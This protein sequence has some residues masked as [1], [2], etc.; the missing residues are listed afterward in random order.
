MGTEVLV[1]PIAGTA[2]RERE[3]DELTEGDGGSSVGRGKKK[4]SG[5]RWILDRS[6]GLRTLRYILK[7]RSARFAC[8]TYLR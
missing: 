7:D 6:D 5:F 4:E 1:D 2:G 3:D 8:G